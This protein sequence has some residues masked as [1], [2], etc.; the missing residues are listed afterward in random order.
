[1]PEE[2]PPPPPEETGPDDP[3]PL[4]CT[5]DDVEIDRGDPR[6]MHPSSRCR[7]RETCLVIELIRMKEK[8]A[9]GS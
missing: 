2:T 1:M 5:E 7:F 3:G 9:G 6:C 4:V 8:R